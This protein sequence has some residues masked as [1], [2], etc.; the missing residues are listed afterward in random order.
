MRKV[1]WSNKAIVIIVVMAML[2]SM[3]MVGCSNVSDNKNVGTAANAAQTPEAE[4]EES[5]EEDVQQTETVPTEEP[6][7]TLEPTT[8]PT[9]EEEV[10]ELPEIDERYE[11][12]LY[13][14]N[15]KEP[16]I[17]LNAPEGWEYAG[18]STSND[19]L[20]SL[21]LMRTNK[22]YLESIFIIEEHE[23]VANPL[24]TD[25]QSVVAP[26]IVLEQEEKAII[27]TAFGKAQI[28]WAAMAFQDIYD[29]HDG[30]AGEEIQ[31]IEGE[32]YFI[33]YREVAAMS[34][35]KGN[36]KDQH[37]V[38]F[39]SDSYNNL[40]SGILEEVLPQMLEPQ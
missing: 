30:G 24:E 4:S 2:S 11:Y 28:Y 18:G 14:F 31:E 35:D 32:K 36:A 27:D 19:I 25:M 1:I 13:C 16:V 22:G 7:S 5:G 38:F 15:V 17:G 6:E 40:Y 3:G 26:Q 37:Q 9:P 12:H 20:L 23:A 29:I 10:V 34:I 33:V 21:D 39:Y 8:E